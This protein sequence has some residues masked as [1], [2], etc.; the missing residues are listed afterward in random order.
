MNHFSK[1]LTTELTV[2][3]IIIAALIGGIFFFKG[4]IDTYAKDT[5]LARSNLIHISNGILESSLLESQYSKIAGYQDLLNTIV[6][7]YY[8]LINLNKDLQSLAAAQNLSYSFSFAGENPKT[9]SGFGSVNFNLSVSSTDLNALLSFL[10]SLE[11]FK[12]LNTINGVTFQS[13]NDGSITMAVR[14]EVFYH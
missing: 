10:N 2:S 3:F 5:V 4:N 14:G 1:R 13:G 7:S 9:Q 6:P 8:D 12:Y 11:H